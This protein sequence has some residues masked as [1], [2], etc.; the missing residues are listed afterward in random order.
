[1]RPEDNVM[2][3]AIASLGIVSLA[4]LGEAEDFIRCEDCGRYVRARPT[5]WQLHQRI[6]CALYQGAEA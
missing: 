5:A 2:A 3:D 1:M 4:P 6:T